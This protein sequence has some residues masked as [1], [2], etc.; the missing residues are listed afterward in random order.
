MGL[1]I[2]T[3]PSFA[4][5]VLQIKNFDFS[6]ETVKGFEVPLSAMSATT[7]QLLS[8]GEFCKLPYD[9]IPVNL[10]APEFYF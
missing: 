4:T 10:L 3:Y 2:R 6:G 5:A 1:C 8:N 9:T 7:T